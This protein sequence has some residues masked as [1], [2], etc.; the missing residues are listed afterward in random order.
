MTI[1]R[2]QEQ[3]LRHVGH[4]FLNLFFGHE[5]LY[6]PLSCCTDP[7]NLKVLTMMVPFKVSLASTLLVKSIIK[8][9]IKKKKNNSKLG[10]GR[11]HLWSRH[12]RSLTPC[13]KV[14]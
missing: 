6:V 13:L 8:Q 7:A 9:T 1:N 10:Q 5:Q 3:T 11:P 12:T 14:P 2:A 4:S